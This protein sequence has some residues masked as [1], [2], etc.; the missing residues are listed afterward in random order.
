MALQFLNSG[1]FA[2]L[3]GIGTT[4][5]VNI[6]TVKA[7]AATID[8][9]STAD[10]QTVGLRAGYLSDGNLAG[11]FRYTTGDAQLYIDNNYTGNNGVYSDINIRNKTASNVLTTR[12]KIKGSTGNVGI[13]NTTPF[14]KLQVGDPDVQSQTMLTIASMYTATPPVQYD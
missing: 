12:I 7:A 9:Q 4:P 11:Y 5:A 14:S 10:N 2:G 13:G 1:Y 8:I 6:L 3:V